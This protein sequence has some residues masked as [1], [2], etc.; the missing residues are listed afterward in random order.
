MPEVEI[1][2]A[3][4]PDLGVLVSLDHSY[5][6]THVWQMDRLNEDGHMSINFRSVRLPRPVRV[7]YPRAIATVSESWLQSNGLL[8]AAIQGTAVGYIHLKV[9][10]EPGTAWVTDLAVAEPMRRKGIGSVLLLAGQE[11]AA[12]RGQRYMILEMQ[13]KNYPAL[14]LCNKLGYELCGFNDQYYS[15]RDIALFFGRLLR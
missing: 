14:R 13:S 12:Q 9:I 7:E 11:W 6:T 15:N 4:L 2:P 1:R 8:V 10:E 3:Q 5:Q